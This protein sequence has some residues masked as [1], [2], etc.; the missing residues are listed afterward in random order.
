MIKSVSRI[1]NEIP[2]TRLLSSKELL[3][4]TCNHCVP[5]LDVLNDP[6]DL[7]EVL[8]VM[9]YLRPFDDLEFQTIGEVVDF[10]SQTLEGLYFIHRQGV[11]Q[12][13]CAAANI[14]MDSGPLFPPGHHPV[15]LDYTPD[16]VSYTSC[17]MRNQRPVRYYFIDFGL[18]SYFKPGEVLLAIGT[19][20]RD[21]E[22][23][24]RSDTRPYNP[25]PLDIFILGNVYLKD[26]CKDMTGW[27]FS[28]L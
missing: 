26:L 24:E 7:L 25:F 22:P 8:M 9:P 17:F 27:T 3:A 15:Q 13:D 16:G 20:G 14:M 1:N 12:R 28:S 5:V 4:D 10:V 2:I 21:K 11:T 23:P 18:S 6:F 19:K